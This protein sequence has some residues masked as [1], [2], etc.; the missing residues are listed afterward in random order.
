MRK[1]VVAAVLAG[2]LALAAAATP[3]RVVLSVRNMTCPACGITIQKA[4][5]RLE[6]VGEVV[7][8]PRAGTVAVVFDPQRAD[9]P[10]IVKAVTDAG[11][12]AHVS[13]RDD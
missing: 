12:P 6:G 13:E 2:W 4:L 8:D 7:V 3:E 11:F 10:A 1:R 5:A 9:V